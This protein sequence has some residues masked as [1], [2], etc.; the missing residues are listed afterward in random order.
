MKKRIEVKLVATFAGDIEDSADEAAIT[1]AIGSAVVT[2]RHTMLVVFDGPGK[3]AGDLRF[4]GAEH[5]VVT[6]PP[7]LCKECGGAGTF[8]TIA[9]RYDYAHAEGCSKKPPRRAIAPSGMA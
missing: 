7:A 6:L 9:N 3:F 5:Q 4:K 2:L 8:D 1:E